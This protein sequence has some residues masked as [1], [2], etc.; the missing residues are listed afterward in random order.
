MLKSVR[1]EMQG[2]MPGHLCPYGPLRFHSK[3]IPANNESHL[4]LRETHMNLIVWVIYCEPHCEV[5]AS[6]IASRETYMYVG[7]Y[8]AHLII[9]VS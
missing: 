8:K 2:R 1:K 4:R 7:Q 6:A 3:G 9:L 5:T